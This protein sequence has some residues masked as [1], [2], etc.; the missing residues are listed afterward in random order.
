MTHH[1]DFAVGLFGL[2]GNPHAIQQTFHITSDEWLN[3]NQIYTIMA[4]AAG[5]EPRLV[6]VPSEIISRYDQHWGEALFGDK[7]HSMIFDNSK[8]RRVVPDYHPRIPFW[9]GAREIM[10]WYDADPARQVVN[11]AVDALQDRIIAAMQSIFPS[12][13]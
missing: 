8:I 10:A 3:W 2:L 7:A 1:C 6:H 12:Q 4:H 5:V 11:P 13:V 9:Q